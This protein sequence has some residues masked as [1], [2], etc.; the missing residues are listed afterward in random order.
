MIKKLQAGDTSIPASGWNEIR[1]FVN[2]YSIPQDTFKNALRNPFLISV[3]NVT[4]AALD[5][6]SIVKIETPTYSRTGSTFANKAVEYG[7][8]M[9]AG[10]PTSEADN[11][12]VLQGGIQVGCIGRAIAS[13]CTACF[14][15]KADNIAYKYA[16]PV[17]N[18][19]DY[20]EGT[21]D[22]TNYRVLWIASG[23]GKKEAYIAIGIYKPKQ[24]I[25]TAT[26]YGTTGGA[27]D[28]FTDI[29]GVTYTVIF[30]N[31]N[32]G[33]SARNFPDIYPYDEILV[34]IDLETGNCYA[35]DY[36]TDY[37]SDS[38]MAFYNSPWGR[39]WEA[40]STPADL[41]AAGFT[42]YRKDKTNA[43]L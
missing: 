28:V 18:H 27:N 25:T 22:V 34:L 39:G 5:P 8:E 15:N 6:L 21:N 20:L 24:Y 12:A 37:E 30:P 2:G 32:S 1:D 33:L 7:V 40:I 13:G 38:I 29:N 42:L 19:S 26:V 17:A 36:P 16:K 9:D 3:K 23:T 4:N 43:I 11:I 35:I 41:A 10:A 14:I 31:S